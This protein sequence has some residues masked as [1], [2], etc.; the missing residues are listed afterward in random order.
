[1][2]TRVVF[3]GLDG[4][5]LDRDRYALDTA[6]PALEH[7][8]RAAV[9]WIPVTSKTF[10][11]VQHYRQLLGNVHPFVVENGGAIFI[12]Q[13]TFRSPFQARCCA[14]VTRWWSGARRT[15]T[16]WPG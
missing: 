16:W 7:M 5:L 2:P 13:A 4:S 9:P 11:E 1:M 12:P 14:T 8:E 6:L 15:M 3:T 10:A